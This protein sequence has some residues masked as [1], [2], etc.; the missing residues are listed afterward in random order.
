MSYELP[1]TTERLENEHID[2]RGTY[3]DVLPHLPPD[4]PPAKARAFI[5]MVF[6]FTA[7]KAAERNGLNAKQCEYLRD[8]Y[9]AE[10]TAAKACRQQIMKCMVQSMVYGLVETG[11]SAL[12]HIDNTK[13]MTPHAI[14]AL[15]NA[16]QGFARLARELPERPEKLPKSVQHDARAALA[17]LAAIQ[18]VVVGPAE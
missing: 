17:E 9:H 6:G 12:T 15:A 4:I 5:D 1:A 14:S 7:S 8:K 11:L 18:D 10:F 16:A 2:A 3:I 13:P